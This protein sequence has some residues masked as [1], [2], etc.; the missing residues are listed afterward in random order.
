MF[1]PVVG[2]LVLITLANN[3][4]ANKPEHP[5]NLTRASSA[6]IPKILN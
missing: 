6:C 1:G 5:Y 4:R 3:E 2:I